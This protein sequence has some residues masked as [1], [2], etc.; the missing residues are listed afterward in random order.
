[1]SF[2]VYLRID[3]CAACGRGEAT[4]FDFNLTHNV[5]EIVER[6]LV[7]GGAGLAKRAAG[8]EPSYYDSRSWGRLEGWK[9]GEV[10]DVI[11]RAVAVS[12]DP[13]RAAEFR[14]L[15][16]PN[17][18]GSLDGVQRCFD[19]LLVACRDHPTATIRTSG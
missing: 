7:A 3:P 4:V 6:C 5:N 9:A 14:G 17:G 2:D 19:E 16:P 12:R 11:S 10:A 13:A 1:M 8:E 18:W 15:Q